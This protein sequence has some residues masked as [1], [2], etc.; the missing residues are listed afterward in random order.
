[1]NWLQ[2]TKEI[3]L[4]KFIFQIVGNKI[5]HYDELITR[6]N[7]SLVTDKDLQIFCEL[8]NDTINIG[9][10]KAIEDYK[11]NLDALGIKVTIENS[12]DNP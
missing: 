9:Y 3:A 1:M 6:L 10:K 12:V 7:N 4:K 11:K 5:T 8:L 2:N